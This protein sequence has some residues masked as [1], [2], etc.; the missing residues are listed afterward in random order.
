[1]DDLQEEHGLIVPDIRITVGYR[2]SVIIVGK[3]NSKSVRGIEDL[4]ERNDIRI[5]ICREAYQRELWDD[6][7]SKAMLTDRI[8]KKIVEYGTGCLDTYQRWR[9]SVGRIDATI[10]FILLRI[11]ISVLIF[12][13]IIGGA[14]I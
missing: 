5:P 13:K 1:M 2:H 12:R 3:G 9:R 7:A 4:A 14:P 6:V 8:R 10:M 11:V